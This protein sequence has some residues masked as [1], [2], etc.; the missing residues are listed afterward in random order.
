M[1]RRMK[2]HADIADGA[3]RTIGNDLG[4]VRVVGTIA[5]RHDVQ[6]LPG[7][8]NRFMSGPRMIG[9]TMRNQRPVNRLHRIDVEIARWT[10]QPLWSGME[11][12]IKAHHCASAVKTFAKNIFLSASR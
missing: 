1:A 12:F 5:Q 6:R 7:R 8:Q 11:Q 10:I 4:A 3:A 9:M 2:G